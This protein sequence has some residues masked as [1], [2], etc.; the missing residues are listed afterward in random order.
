MSALSGSLP[1]SIDSSSICVDDSASSHE[2]RAIIAES[3][4]RI[5]YGHTH[6][7]DRWIQAQTRALITLDE[8][9]LAGL[10]GDQRRAHAEQLAA[11]R[12]GQLR[13][14]PTVFGELT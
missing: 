13:R 12:A 3:C 5:L 10:T 4:L 8:G 14:L 6:D 7:G 9:L 2:A 1:S 11:M